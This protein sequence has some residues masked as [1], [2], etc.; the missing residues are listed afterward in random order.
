[1]KV[2]MIVTSNGSE[3]GLTLKTFEGGRVYDLAPRLA[4]IF[5]GGGMAEAVTA[6]PKPEPKTKPKPAAKRAVKSARAP[7]ENKGK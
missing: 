5:I 6:E 3:D 1:M 2:R 7:R 4:E